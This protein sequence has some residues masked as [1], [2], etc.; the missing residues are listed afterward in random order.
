MTLQTQI[1]IFVQKLII[2][3]NYN[4]SAN[5]KINLYSEYRLRDLQVHNHNIFFR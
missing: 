4:K 5:R 2:I 3:I 1:R